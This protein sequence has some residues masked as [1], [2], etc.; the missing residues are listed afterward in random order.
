D[1]EV[2]APEGEGEAAEGEGEAAEGEGEAAEGEGEA[3]EGEGEAAEGEGE[4]VEG[5][6]EPEARVPDPARLW[7][8]AWWPLATSAAVEEPSEPL[9][10]RVWAVGQTP[11][12]AGVS[13]LTVEIGWGPGDHHPGSEAWQ[14]TRATHNPDCGTC[15]NDDEYAA[16]ARPTAPG[17]LRWAARVLEEGFAPLYCDRGDAGR[18]GSNDGYAAADAPLLTVP[19]GTD[20]KIVSLNLRCLLDDWE[21]RKELI[22]DELLA[23]TPDLVGF[24]EAC[25]GGGGDNVHELLT[26]LQERTGLPYTA[27]RASTHRSWDTYQEGLALLTPHPITSWQ[28]DALPA[29]AFPRKLL[30]ARVATPAGEVLFATTHLDHANPATRAAQ[31]TE[32]LR[33]LQEDAATVPARPIVLTGDFN[34]GPGGE[35]VP[36]LAQ[37]GLT[38]L[39]STLH[40]GEAGRT[41]P[42]TNPQD[43]IDYLW[44]LPGEAGWQA[45][46]VELAFTATAGAIHASD[47]LGL[48]G[49]VARP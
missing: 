24:Q 45:R 48:A 7:C 43:R 39:W 10:A 9:Y 46:S 19:G 1:G 16:Q 22:L 47:H 33:L 8:A 15:G 2:D 25:A 12:V 40:P 31:A 28:A 26:G 21:V 11:S 3:A 5:E 42:A 32:V 27:V 49:T 36:L 23:R 35:V 29:G 13:G 30:R 6:G 41:F 34:E 20:L 14:W 18:L 17:S 4:G 37:G 38:D 44:L